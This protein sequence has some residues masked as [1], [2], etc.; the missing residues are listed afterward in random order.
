M[1]H[2]AGHES[3]EWHSDID[4]FHHEP[5]RGPQTLLSRSVT[6]EAGDRVEYR[7]DPGPGGSNTSCDWSYVRDLVFRQGGIAGT[8]VDPRERIF[9]DDFE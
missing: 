5:D 7:V 4:P 8:S 6:V 1:L 2:H 3:V 9:N